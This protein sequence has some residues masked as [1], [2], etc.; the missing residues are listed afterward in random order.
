MTEM[1]GWARKIIENRNKFY[2]S[3]MVAENKQK[4][5]FF[6][7]KTHPVYKGIDMDPLIPWE[8]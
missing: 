4:T 1:H 7:N 5:I 6:C 8:R 2:N 3:E